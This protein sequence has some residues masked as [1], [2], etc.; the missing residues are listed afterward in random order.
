VSD[1]FNARSASF[2]S[3][4]EMLKLCHEKIRR[5]ARLT[6]RL[7]RH[8]EKSSIDAAAQ[9]A[10]ELVLRYFTV[11]APLHHQDEEDDLFPALRNLSVESLGAMEHQALHRNL[12]ALEAEHNQLTSLWNEVAVWLKAL[13]Q[14][15]VTPPPP[16]LNIFAVTYTAH[17]DR[18]EKLI[19]PYAKAL[20]LDTLRQIGQRMAERRILTQVKQIERD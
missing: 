17:A 11:A 19:Y 12:Q 13:C 4:I 2:D 16:C 7:G 15:T 18:E 6:Q 3:P 8:M 9:E 1:F 20:K 10:A 14:H 5:F